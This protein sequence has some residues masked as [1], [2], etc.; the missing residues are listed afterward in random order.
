[1]ECRGVAGSCDIAEL[2]DGLSAD[3]PGNMFLGMSTICRPLAG[4]CD[5]RERCTGTMPMCPPNE[6]EAAGVMCAAPTGPCTQGA[7]CT[8]SS[9][10]CPGQTNEPNGTPCQ[11]VDLCG[12]PAICRACS[13]GSC[14]LEP[15]WNG[16]CQPSCGILGTICGGAEQCCPSG[17]CTVQYPYTSNDCGGRC[18][19]GAGTCI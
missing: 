18:C 15:G 9:S 10:N 1:M 7:F 3:C 11:T 14:T 5:L 8:G 13:G 4:P 17:T 16:S 19:M 2:C 6:L 12:T